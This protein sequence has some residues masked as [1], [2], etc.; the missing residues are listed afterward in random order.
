[1]NITTLT[2]ARQP[3]PLDRPTVE[4]PTGYEGACARLY[5]HERLH[6]TNGSRAAR[7]ELLAARASDLELAARAAERM[8]ETYGTLAVMADITRRAAQHAASTQAI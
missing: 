3:S 4:A 1:M 7:A 6:D 5:R 8:G 2:N